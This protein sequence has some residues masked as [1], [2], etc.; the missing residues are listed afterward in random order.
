MIEVSAERAT[1]SEDD[2]PMCGEPL[3]FVL[4]TEFFFCPS[5]G[6]NNFEK[7]WLCQ[8]A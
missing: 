2:C 1:E 7:T 4:Y 3:I 5:C 8:M 6:E